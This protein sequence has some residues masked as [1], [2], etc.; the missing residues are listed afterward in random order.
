[1]GRQDRST[2]RGFRALS[3][4]LDVLA[5]VQR[6]ASV[7]KRPNGTKKSMLEVY[8]AAA[9]G[10]EARQ[11]SA[12]KGKRKAQL[13]AAE[14]AAHVKRYRESGAPSATAYVVGKSAKP[15]CYKFAEEPPL[16]YTSQQRAWFDREVTEWWVQDVF[17]P[18]VRKVRGDVWV[19]LILDNCPA[20][21]CNDVDKFH[22]HKVFV[23]FL[24]KNMTSR[25]Q[26]AD[27]R[28]GD[29]ICSQDQDQIQVHL[30]EEVGVPL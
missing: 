10:S 15:R 25:F 3:T 14:R 1:V 21:P 7:A 29:D 6:S 11:R 9:R 16:P 22:H 2:P 27:C 12:G 5:R 26:P 30:S 4:L 20:H 17:V 23:I 24:P 28:H 18:H 19:V 13:S 8:G